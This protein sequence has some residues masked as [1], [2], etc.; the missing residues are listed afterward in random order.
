[1]ETETLKEKIERWIIL[2]E[3]LDKEEK[4]IYIKDISGNYFMGNIVLIGEEKIT[5]NCFAPQQRKGER[6]VVRWVNVIK[7]VEYIE[8]FAK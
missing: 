4:P 6:E 7:C 2:S 5:I 3:Q 1:M 8:E